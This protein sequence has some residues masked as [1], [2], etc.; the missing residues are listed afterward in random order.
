MLP[1][2]AIADADWNRIEDLLPG[3]PGQ[4][5]KAAKDNRL[6]IDAVLWVA[7]TGAPWRDLPERFGNWNSVWRRFSR[8]SAKGVWARVLEVLADAD[9]EWLVLDSTV[10]RAHPHAAGAKKS[11]TAPGARRTRLWAAAGAGSRPRSTAASA[12][13]GC[14]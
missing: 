4:H 12:A 7:K 2:H 14:R 8:W 3:R 13:W 10:V 1:R 6:F 9:L 5:G 11:G